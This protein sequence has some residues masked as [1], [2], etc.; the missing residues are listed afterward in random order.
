MD[1]ECGGLYSPRGL[2]ELDLTERPRMH[3]GGSLAS[4][5]LTNPQLGVHVFDSILVRVTKTASTVI[6]KTCLF[7]SISSYGT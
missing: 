1:R 6:F 3:T 7:L 4:P 5:G 2:E